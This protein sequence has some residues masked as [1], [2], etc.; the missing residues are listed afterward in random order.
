MAQAT[1]ADSS[2]ESIRSI[3]PPWPG[4]MLPM[5]L[6]PRS[7]LIVDSVRS[8]S[9]AETARASPSMAPAHHEPP[10]I[11]ITVPTPAMT[12]AT[13]DP[14]A[15]SHDFLGLMDGVI[16]CLPAITP[17]AKPPMSVSYT[18][19]RAHETRHDLVCRLLLEK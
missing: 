15:P 14:A 5:S 7:R 1:G 6:M 12:Q 13:T 9:V 11:T 16:G 2:S 8:P 3:N 10:S 19:L 4:R 18:H 17:T